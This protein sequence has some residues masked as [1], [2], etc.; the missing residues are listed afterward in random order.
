V[1]E[2]NRSI[3][4]Q[5]PRDSYPSRG[6]VTLRA[7]TVADCDA[8]WEWNF[9]PDV[10]AM[11]NDPSIVELARHAA[12]YVDRLAQGAFWIVEHEGQG[13]G[14]V[15]IDH[16]RIS[17]ALATSARGKGAGK[18]AIALACEAWAGPVV[19]QIRGDNQPSRAAFE[20]C[21]FVTTGSS[22]RVMTY[23]WS[24]E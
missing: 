15:R 18:R 11:S 14:C 21:G 9:A 16:G 7:A 12:W 24:P 17:I 4:G 22:E 20:A 23:Q 10:R 19:A 3:A 8:V 5:H 6:S 1:T 2:G 13:V